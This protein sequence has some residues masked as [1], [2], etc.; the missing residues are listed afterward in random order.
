MRNYDKFVVS[1]E[2]ADVYASNRFETFKEAEDAARQRT[3]KYSEPYGIFA[4]VAKT[5]LPKAVTD[6]EIVKVEVQKT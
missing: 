3:V 6:I 5:K 1:S 4:M 2:E